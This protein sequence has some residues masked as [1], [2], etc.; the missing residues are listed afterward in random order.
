[1]SELQEKKQQELPLL[2][3][4]DC[5]SVI[6]TGDSSTSHSFE[7]SEV[8]DDCFNTNYGTCY[9]C[10][11]VFSNSDIHVADG[12]SYCS[13]CFSER[14]VPCYDCD[15]PVERD[16]SYSCDH[17]DD[18]NSYCQNCYEREHD[19]DSDANFNSRDWTAR[20]VPFLAGTR[21]TAERKVGIELEA[22][23]TGDS[24]AY[25][26]DNVPSEVGISEDGSL[27][28][29]VEIVTPPAMGADAERIIEESCEG[30]KL[31]GYGIEK[32]CGLHIHL[33]A[34]EYRK[35][36]KNFARLWEFGIASESIIYQMLPLSRR[37]NRYCGSLLRVNGTAPEGAPDLKKCE[38][39]LYGDDQTDS[40]IERA[41]RN[42]YD[43]RRY[44]GLNLHSIF[45]RGTCE[46]RYHSGTME[47]EKIKE[48]IVLWMLIMDVAKRTPIRESRS[49]AKLEGEAKL[50]KFLNVI[51]ADERSREYIRS[52]I[53][54][55]EGAEN[56]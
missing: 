3:C 28:N 6:K 22:E 40:E 35:N 29:G 20:S 13:D 36:G 25:L 1:M 17:C 52:R 26:N 31:S 7:G 39:K 54:Q 33:D 23:K 37:N 11:E 27:D 55:F 4:R 19:H 16:V 14:F 30:L 47:P 49:L 10:S 53:A 42:R 12:C 46:V 48:W 34:P 32:S 9:D 2:R 15:E 8:C 21:I 44:C 24:D 51:R 18:G 41:K 45:Y 38:K 56:D 50:R 5:D 43:S